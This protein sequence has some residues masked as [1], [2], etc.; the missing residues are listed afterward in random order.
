M[1]GFLTER[2]NPD[3]NKR[4]HLDVVNE[5]IRDVETLTNVVNNGGYDEHHD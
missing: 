4:E 5:R 1:C 2:N 3:G